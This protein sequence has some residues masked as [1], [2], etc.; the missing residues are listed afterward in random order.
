MWALVL[1]AFSVLLLTL[2][3]LSYFP[4]L[5]TD[6]IYFLKNEN[7]I[8]NDSAVSIS[9]LT[10]DS[11]HKKK[12]TTANYP[13]LSKMFEAAG[14]TRFTA[15]MFYNIDSLPRT[16]SIEG[17]QEPSINTNNKFD[18][19]KAEFPICTL[20]ASQTCQHTGFVKLFNLFSDSLYVE[21]LQAPDAGRPGLPKTQLCI[22]TQDGTTTPTYYIETFPLPPFPLQ[23]WIMLTISRKG[24]SLKVYYNT[25]VVASV[26]TTKTISLNSAAATLSL[27]DPSIQ[28]KAQYLWM[29]FGT[30]EITEITQYYNSLTDT[31]GAPIQTSIGYP[32][33]FSLCPSGNCLNG[34][35]VRP[36][37][38]LVN[39]NFEYS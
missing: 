14:N 36:A 7:N 25:A 39:W 9:D 34:P 23:K 17:C 38:P 5:Y 32:T 27:G 22:R 30:K 2:A 35:Q 26:K 11:E 13:N 33:N 29:P 15:L 19:V 3:I 18:C 21:L 37:N 28:G 31:N 10:N 20:S 16:G 8:L 24:N 12:L 6:G 4:K 1:I